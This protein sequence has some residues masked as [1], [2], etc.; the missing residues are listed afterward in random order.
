VDETN[1]GRVAQQLHRFRFAHRTVE[2]DVRAHRMADVD[3]HAHARDGAAN[4]VVVQDLARLAHHF[5]LFRRIALLFE[6]TGERDYV[7]RNGLRPH[8]AFDH[9][10][11]ERS[12][13]SELLDAAVELR[14]LR[15]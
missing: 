13:A 4:L 9:G 7:A 15:V 1:T 8:F 5:P 14:P 3:G 10:R 6:G 2:L 12:C 11:A